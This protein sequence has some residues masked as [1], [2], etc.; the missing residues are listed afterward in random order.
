MLNV[1]LHDFI[2]ILAGEV[3]GGVITREGGGPLH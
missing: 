1:V 2:Y 3:G